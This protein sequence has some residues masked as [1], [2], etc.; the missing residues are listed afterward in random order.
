MWGVQ[1]SA[2]LQGGPQPSHL[3]LQL[4]AALLEAGDV[5]P[6]S[7]VFKHHFLVDQTCTLQHLL[8]GRLP[9][10]GLGTLL[11]E[12]HDQLVDDLLCHAWQRNAA[13]DVLCVEATLRRLFSDV[14]VLLGRIAWLLHGQWIAR[15][16]MLRWRVCCP[17]PIITTLHIRYYIA[18]R[19]VQVVHSH[20]VEHT[21]QCN[22]SW[23]GHE[24]THGDQ[25]SC[26]SLG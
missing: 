12:L 21:G 18:L 26:E 20:G 6:Q 7:L 22:R 1:H 19:Q 2:Y 3:E 8:E 9:A 10:V 5:L 14:A 13:G 16:S 25:S 15:W 17:K 24:L 23:C 4:V 11:G